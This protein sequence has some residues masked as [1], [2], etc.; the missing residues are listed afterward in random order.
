MIRASGSLGMSILSDEVLFGDGENTVSQEITGSQS[1]DKIRAGS[2][3]VG[4]FVP[5]VQAR[6]QS[7]IKQSMVEKQVILDIESLFTFEQIGFAKTH[8][9]IAKKKQ[10]AKNI[11]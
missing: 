2:E 4:P 3:K 6:F 11:Q 9:N 10:V 7:S 8:D 1:E 5:E